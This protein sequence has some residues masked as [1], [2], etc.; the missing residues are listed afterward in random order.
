MHVVDTSND[1]LVPTSR[2]SRGLRLVGVG[3][4]L[5]LLL[6]P[7]LLV[8]STPSVMNA[9]TNGQVA[10]ATLINHN[11]SDLDGRVDALEVKSGVLAANMIRSEGGFV[12]AGGGSDSVL[13][14]LTVDLTG[15][16]GRWIHIYGGTAL[17]EPTNTSNTAMIRVV[18]DNGTTQTVSAI[19]QGIGVYSNI[20]WDANAT[21]S[22]AT[23][24]YFKVTAAYA[25]PN[26]NIRL[27]GGLEGAAFYWGDQPTYT[28]YDGNQAGGYLG[29]A[30]F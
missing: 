1:T 11:F 10:D 7:P 5:G 29:Y 17:S 12:A 3:A 16:T 28:G 6:V 20:S 18:I 19:R 8:A 30:I 9:F 25:V 13:L 4:G 27:R 23:Q 24:G 22:M 2:R 26:V 21:A 14:S 15:M